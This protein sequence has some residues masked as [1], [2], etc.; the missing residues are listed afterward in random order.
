MV[1][2]AV[3][4]PE[5]RLPANNA[6]DLRTNANARVRAAAARHGA[7]EA[8]MPPG[9]NAALNREYMVPTES[10]YILRLTPEQRK[11]MLALE[12]QGWRF[13]LHYNA[14]N[15]HNDA[16]TAGWVAYHI[17]HSK[18]RGSW[19]QLDWTLPELIEQVERMAPHL[20]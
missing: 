18:W 17:G 15:E 14:P 10:E 16:L 6:A 3:G 2:R 8:R 12:H 20:I 7:C 19:R 9:R 5:A 4:A 13:G 1:R 11:R